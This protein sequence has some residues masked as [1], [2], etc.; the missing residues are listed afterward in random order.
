MPAKLVEVGL[1]V[2]SGGAMVGQAGKIH[3]IQI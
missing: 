1:F 3:R 2:K